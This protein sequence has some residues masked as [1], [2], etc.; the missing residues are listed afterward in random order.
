MTNLTWVSQYAQNLPRIFS[1]PTSNAPTPPP[2][3]GSAAESPQVS[4]RK[5]LALQLGQTTACWDLQEKLWG[6]PWLKMMILPLK[7]ALGGGNILLLRIKLANFMC[8]YPTNHYSPFLVWISKD[9]YCLSTRATNSNNFLPFHNN[10]K[11][12]WANINH[13]FWKIDADCR[14][15]KPIIFI[16][17]ST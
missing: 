4:T 5:F 2:P 1:C 17:C 8:F 3:A 9:S 16:S 10:S 12:N 7:F 13:M 11:P 15:S 6:R 14:V